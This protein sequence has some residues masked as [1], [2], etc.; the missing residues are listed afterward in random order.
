VTS[1]R[2]RLQRIRDQASRELKAIVAKRL[3][4]QDATMAATPLSEFALSKDCSSCGKALKGNRVQSW[5][6]ERLCGDC[7]S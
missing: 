3:A 2:E 7:D 4:E 1:E 5:N 6:T